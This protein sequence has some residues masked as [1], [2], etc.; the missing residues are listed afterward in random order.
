MHC[1]GMD[2]D[3]VGTG[4]QGSIVITHLAHDLAQLTS[5]TVANHS[6]THLAADAEGNLPELRARVSWLPVTGCRQLR[7]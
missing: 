6:V 1:S 4:G 2:D 7:S 5:E 3:Q